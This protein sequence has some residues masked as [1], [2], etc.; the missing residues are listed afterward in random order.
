M[1]AMHVMDNTQYAG[2]EPE[3]HGWDVNGITQGKIL[4]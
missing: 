3:K 1:G 2:R 4:C